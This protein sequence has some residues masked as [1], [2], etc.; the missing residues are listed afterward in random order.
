VLK[1]RKNQ[2]TTR[3]RSVFASVRSVLFS[4]LVVGAIAIGCKSSDPAPAA[5]SADISGNYKITTHSATVAG[6]VIDY[7]QLA[8]VFGSKCYQDLVISLKT[9][10]TVSTNN[11]A[12]CA[13]DD[14]NDTFK[15]AKWAV[16]GSTLSI[17]P[18]STPKEDYT[19]T[20][21]SNKL[22]LTRTATQNGQTGQ[23][24]LEM[25]KQ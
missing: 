1:K 18:G 24:K 20:F 3:M 4:F 14:T 16:N 21:A 15:G 19:Y 8:S 9:D 6:Q 5:S 10:G 17:T 13:D 7:M 23:I 25:T 2:F 11:P 22:T 12:S